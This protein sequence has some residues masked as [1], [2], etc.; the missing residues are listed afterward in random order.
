MQHCT[1][2]SL[3]QAISYQMGQHT[4]STVS[5]VELNAKIKGTPTSKKKQSINFKAHNWHSI[6]WIKIWAFS[7]FMPTKFNLQEKIYTSFPFTK[8]IKHPFFHD[9]AIDLSQKTWTLPL[10]CD[11][12]N[13]SRLKFKISSQI[14]TISIVSYNANKISKTEK[15]N[16]VPADKLRAFMSE[17]RSRSRPEQAKN[18]AAPKLWFM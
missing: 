9:D 14:K 16:C 15:L 13:L 12:F 1:A 10:K 6:V 2:H 7:F 17:F 3:F 18:R 4:T 5:S 8:L 11:N